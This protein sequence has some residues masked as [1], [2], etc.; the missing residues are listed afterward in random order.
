MESA[1]YT[2]NPF[3]FFLHIKSDSCSVFLSDQFLF[4]TIWFQPVANSISKADGIPII[5]PLWSPFVISAHKY[6]Q[7]VNDCPYG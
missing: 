5:F 1:S 6:D 7:F 4:A 3:Y 2:Y